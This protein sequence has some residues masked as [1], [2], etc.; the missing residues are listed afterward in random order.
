[1]K[2]PPMNPE[3]LALWERLQ[4]LRLNDDD[5]AFDFTARLAREQG[6]SRSFAERVVSE[7]RRFLFLAMNA[8]HVVTPSEEV[9]EVW[10]LHLVYTR[11]YWHDLCQETLGR[12]LHHQPTKGGPLEAAKFRGLYQQTL[13][14][15]E[16]FFGEVPPADIWPGVAERFAPRRNRQVDLTKAWVIPKPRLVKPT[17]EKLGVVVG[18]AILLA[19]VTG[20]AAELQVF[21]LRGPQFLGYY[22]V[23]LVGAFL[24]S[25]LLTKVLRGGGDLH[26][27]KEVD[28]P[29]QL[30][31][32]GGGATRFVEALIAK[33]FDRN[34]LR[35]SGTTHSTSRI[36]REPGLKLPTDFSPLEARAYEAI[37][38]TGTTAL[39]E[40]QCNLRS[41]AEQ[42]RLELQRSG[43]I[44]GSGSLLFL[45]LVA[46]LPLLVVAI[47]GAIKIS[48]GLSRD[49]PVG[50]L[51]ILV[52]ATIAI[53]VWRIASVGALT[54]AGR[55]VWKSVTATKL[56]QATAS[57][58]PMDGGSALDPALVVA[59][60]GPAALT[61]TA[62]AD[63]H[64]ALVPPQPASSSG[65]DAGCGDG[66]SGCGGGGCGGC[67]S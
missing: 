65:G 9:D 10:H 62:H 24:L 26:A 18:S 38:A 32:M 67:G 3:E 45:R 63:L 25:F 28:D 6:W 13:E 58:P 39:L 60:L 16:R 35:I 54:P 8:G 48:V 34:L 50:F 56:S 40:L 66:G 5:A 22:V 57:K 1:M 21:D 23:A 44:Y 43:L 51:V 55:K 7:Y 64:R 15:Y 47:A 2:R 12:P 29:Y 4:A 20:C 37:P 49:K 33:L 61:T 30:A 36:E 42:T 31:L 52:I 11:S 53:L 46:A 17:P 59:V 14:S 41:E 19:A 27:P